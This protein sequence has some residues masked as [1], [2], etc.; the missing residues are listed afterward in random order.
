[1]R[2]L[3]ALA[4]V[5][6]LA[7]CAEAPTAPAALT[8][9]QEDVRV[10]AEVPDEPD[11]VAAPA[12]VGEWINNSWVSVRLVNWSVAPDADGSGNGTYLTFEVVRNHDPTAAVVANVEVGWTWGSKHGIGAQSGLLTMRFISQPRESDAS[13]TVTMHVFEGDDQHEVVAP[14]VWRLG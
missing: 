7:G 4:L 11:E 5:A 13:R 6:I 3:A 1:M 14:M 9:P 2:A 8:D 10:A 12:A